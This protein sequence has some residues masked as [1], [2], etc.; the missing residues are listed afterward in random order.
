MSQLKNEVDSMV[1]GTKFHDLPLLTG[2][3]RRDPPKADAQGAAGPLFGTTT[4]DGVTLNG[5]PGVLGVDPASVSA[6]SDTESGVYEV[7]VLNGPTTGKVTGNS[8]AAPIPASAAPDPAIQLAITG[9]NGSATIDLAHG[10]GP[11]T[12]AADINLQ[13]ATTGVQASVQQPFGPPFNYLVLET[14]GTG[15]SQSV[16]AVATAID[17]L[18]AGVD[19]TGF[20]TAPISNTGSDLA[21]TI[22]GAAAKVTTTPAGMTFSLRSPGNGADGLSFSV[23]SPIPGT[24]TAG[25]HPFSAGFVNVQAFPREVLDQ[26]LKIQSGPNSTDNQQLTMR[27]MTIGSMAMTGPNTLGTI[28][29]TTQ[30]GSLAAIDVADA[31]TT[32]IAGA[33]TTVGGDIRGL[34]SALDNASQAWNSQVTSS[35]RIMDADMAAETAS[36]AKAQIQMQ[37]GNFAVSTLS[38]T[39]TRVLALVTN[40]LP[41]TP[42]APAMSSGGGAQAS[43]MGSGGGGGGGMSAAAIGALLTPATS[44]AH[45]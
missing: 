43:V 15:S 2:V 34:E 17:P 27:P 25:P 35:S 19:Y 3:E 7:I 18:A 38:S 9:P 8:I 23:P 1:Q 12:W 24:Y 28:D 30:A 32:Q 33:R 16:S 6:T 44:S 31:M 37:T 20:G 11:A 5:D 26:S 10:T 21:A 36:I 40:S 22:N 45:T 42:G 4:F 14:V 29:I 41:T 13:T 39:A